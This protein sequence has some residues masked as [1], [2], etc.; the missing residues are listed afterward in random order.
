MK[1]IAPA[2]AIALLAACNAP[3]PA[4]NNVAEPAPAA[5]PKVDPCSLLTAEE[6]SE[7]IGDKIVATAGDSDSCRYSTDDSD[8]VELEYSAT[9]GQRLIDVDRRAGAVLADMGQSVDKEGGAGADVNAMTNE[10]GDPADLGD[11]AL[12]GMGG[13]LS[14]RLGDAYISITPPIVHSRLTN[15]GS[16]LVSKEEKQAMAVALASKALTRLQ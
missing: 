8:G 2:L 4:A 6:V 16:V 11:E 12:F 9:G 1:L 7:V 15:R 10:G 5:G 3:E 14:V 13:Q